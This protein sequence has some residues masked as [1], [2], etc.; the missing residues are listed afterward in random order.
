MFDK[1]KCKFPDGAIAI[2]TESF[3]DESECQTILN[4][5]A[6]EYC[7]QGTTGNFLHVL[8]RLAYSKGKENAG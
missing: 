3:P 6:E 4:E 1:P 2:A 7:R 8:I 5:A